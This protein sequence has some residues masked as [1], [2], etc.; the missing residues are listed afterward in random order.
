M[1][2]SPIAAR[3]CGVTPSVMN[4]SI[5]PSSSR[6]PERPVPG[7][8]DIHGELHDPLQD[9][10][11]RQL[12]GERQPGLDQQLGAITIDGGLDHVQSL[13]RRGKG[14]SPLPSCSIDLPAVR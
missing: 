6:T 14:L 10:V 3:S 12:R 2:G 7:A 5:R 1:G 4:C 8:R 13:T 9:G 11:E